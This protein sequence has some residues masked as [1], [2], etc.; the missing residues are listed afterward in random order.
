LPSIRIVKTPAGEAPER[1]RRAW[2]GVVLPLPADGSGSRR[3]HRTFGVVSGPTSTLATLWALLRGRHVVYDGYAVP[4]LSAVE[5]L[6]QSDPEAAQ[7]WRDH[8]PHLL[9]PQGRFVFEA[10]VCEELL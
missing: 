6:G 9:R 2:I 1:I 7:W 8:A 3:T 4:T 10:D 5:A